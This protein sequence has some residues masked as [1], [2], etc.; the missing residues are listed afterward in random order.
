MEGEEGL[1]G[2]EKTKRGGNGMESLLLVVGAGVMDGAAERKEKVRC[3]L[4][5]KLKRSRGRLSRA[6]SRVS[7]WA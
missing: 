7:A 3:H 4:G 5:G 2:R 1:E 6:E